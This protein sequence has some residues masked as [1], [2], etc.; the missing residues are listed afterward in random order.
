[1]VQAGVGVERAPVRH[2]PISK[3]PRPLQ[4]FLAQRTGPTA[5][6]PHHAQEG[7]ASLGSRVE[8][9]GEMGSAQTLHPG[10]GA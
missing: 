10:P 3:A 7:A 8:R 6:A 5:V 9:A 2:P 1:M 4:G